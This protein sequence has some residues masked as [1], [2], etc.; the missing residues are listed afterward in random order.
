[1]NTFRLL[2]A[3]AGAT[4]FSVCPP[5]ADPVPTNEPQHSVE[6][7][8]TIPVEVPPC[9][10]TTFS[11]WH[12]IPDCDL[13]G[14]QTWILVSDELPNRDAAL[15]LMTSCHDMGGVWA[16]DDYDVIVAYCIDIDY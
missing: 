8:T 1:M 14:S 3:G 9:A 13:D 6:V 7:T 2:A 10:R 15:N 5:P 11:D 4:I 16:Y 12:T